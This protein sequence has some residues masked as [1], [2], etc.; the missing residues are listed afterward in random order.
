M[1]CLFYFPRKFEFILVVLPEA[2]ESNPI[3]QKSRNEQSSKNMVI[4]DCFLIFKNI[5]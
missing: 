5:E 2:I 4:E 3:V 1:Y